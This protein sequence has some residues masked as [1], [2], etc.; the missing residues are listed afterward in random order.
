MIQLLKWHV[1]VVLF[2]TTK[3]NVHEAGTYLARGDIRHQ[4]SQNKK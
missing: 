4:N 1:V 2:T 3:L